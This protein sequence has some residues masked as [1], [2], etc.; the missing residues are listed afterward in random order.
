[1]S[2]W[3]FK[4]KKHLLPPGTRLQYH[5]RSDE[6]SKKLGDLIVEDLLAMC[7]VMAEQAAAGDIV[8]GINVPYRLPNGKTK[9]LDVAIGTPVMHLGAPKLGRIHVFPKT[10]RNKPSPIDRLLVSIEEKAT[11][12]EH[13][14]SQPRVFSELN[15]AH[16]IVHQA[17]RWTVSAGVEMLNIADTFVSPLRQAP[18]RP[19]K[20]TLHN[21]PQV[22]DN[23]VK[24]LR[25]LPQRDNVGGIGLEAFC[26]I[27]VN[28]DNQGRVS[29]HTGPPA[30]GPGD[31]DYYGTFL[32]RICRLYG[33]RFTDIGNLP[34]REGLSI[35]DALM[36]VSRDYKG[37]LRSVGRLAVDQ[38][39]PGAAELDAVLLGVEVQVHGELPEVEEEV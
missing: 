37:L 21:Q 26:T 17:D 14:K 33:E 1:M 9:A 29:L 16:A 38:E 34:S 39:L 30:P 10:P 5:S 22:T 20:V 4:D 6:H 2:T 32:E 8:Y 19:I 18:D 7:P 25:K 27:V 35:E 24:H 36:K 3:E 15:D 11:M 31:I 12:T 23:M 13:G 28:A